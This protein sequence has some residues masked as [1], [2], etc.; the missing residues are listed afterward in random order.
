MNKEAK[1]MVYAYQWSLRSQVIHIKGP[2][3]NSPFVFIL[4]KQEIVG[5]KCII[6]KL[7]IQ[8]NMREHY[9]FIRNF[10][11]AISQTQVFRMC[12]CEISSFFPSDNF[13]WAI[14]LSSFSCMTVKLSA[15]IS[16]KIIIEQ[17]VETSVPSKLDI[18]HQGQAILPKAF[19]RWNQWNEL[20]W[21]R[22]ASTTS[23]LKASSK[24]L[25]PNTEQSFAWSSIIRIYCSEIISCTQ[26]R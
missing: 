18:W 11:R 8:G 23:L 17:K 4:S 13:F 26:H 22:V 5:V 12:T 20:A 15:L 24:G 14:K 7:V 16:L 21:K 3:A 10:F 6:W 1:E 25:L 9:L 2:A 19:E